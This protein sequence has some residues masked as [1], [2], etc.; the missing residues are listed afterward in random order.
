MDGGTNAQSLCFSLTQILLRA[1]LPLPLPPP[2][3]PK[4]NTAGAAA[5]IIPATTHH[6]RFSSLFLLFINL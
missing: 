3:L 2:L 5:L 4:A 1:L 6:V